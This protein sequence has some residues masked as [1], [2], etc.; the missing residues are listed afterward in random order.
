M[1]VDNDI[2][3]RDG[4]KWRDPKHFLSM[5]VPLAGPRVQYVHRVLTEKAG[6]NPTTIRVLDIGC[7]GGLVAE[8]MT[9]LGYTVTGVDP[10]APSIAAAQL[11]SRQNG[12]E[13]SFVVGSGEALPCET[14]AFDAACSLDV[15]EHVDD[16]DKV[17]AEV[18]RVLKP[19]GIFVFDTINRTFLSRLLVIHIMQNWSWTSIMSPNF[20]DWKKFVKPN[21]LKDVLHAH[22]LRVGEFVGFAPHGNPLKHLQMLRRLKHGIITYRELGQYLADRLVFG[23]IMCVSYA[24]YAT[25]GSS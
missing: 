24:G 8:E 19:G 1:S 15:L 4:D 18:V 9:R 14:S 21:E 25:A 7:G 20:H 17:V 3:N 6:L 13:I 5:L 23:R 16:V 11:Q 12:L 10:S 2:Y 22:G